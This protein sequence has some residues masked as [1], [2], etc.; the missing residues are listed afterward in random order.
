MALIDLLPKWENK[1]VLIIGE[2][3]IDRY[4]FGQADKISP[5][6][7]VPN[8]KIE[9]HETYLGAIGLVLQFIK[10]LGGVPDICTIV[11][12]DY[13]GNYF[14]KKMKD[15]NINPANIVVDS[16]IS[17]PQITR[18][19][20][21]NQHLLRLE[22]DYSMEISKETIKSFFNLIQSNFTEID[23]II[24]LDYGAGELF[25]DEFIIKLLENLKKNYKNVP[26]IARPNISNYYLYED[27]DLM[28]INLQ[29]ALSNFS[30]DCCTET[31]I[32]IAGKRIINSSKCKN[33]LLNYLETDS[34]LFFKDQ[35]NVERIKPLLT[36][37]VRSYVAVGSTIMAVLGLVYASKI[38][39]LEGVKIAMSAAA[40]SASL[41]PV[42]FFN[43]DILAKYIS[44]VFN[45]KL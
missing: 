28:K 13:E 6:A 11:G 14:I 26:I 3:L 23:S 15:L 20:A 8:V 36:Q 41:P 24:I 33:L 19:K 27:I 32:I 43:S 40:L 45:N 42:E 10:S 29:K 7:P 5:D 9:R 16:E 17:T 12:D 37:P 25:R 38:S 39:A 18:I 4:I 44:T 35:E 31:S 21:K 30:I 2:A 1:K 34:Y 22:T